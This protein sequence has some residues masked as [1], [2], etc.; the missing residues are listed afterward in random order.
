MIIEINDKKYAIHKDGLKFKTFIVVEYYDENESLEPLRGASQKGFS[1]TARCI[2]K[3]A[4]STEFDVLKL[5]KDVANDDSKKW[6][7]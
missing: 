7:N 5:L 1:Q 4:K 2:A 3:H 6:R